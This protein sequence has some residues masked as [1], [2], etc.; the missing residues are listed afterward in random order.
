[1]KIINAMALNAEV[2]LIMFANSS[3]FNKYVVKLLKT[4]GEDDLDVMNARDLIEVYWRENINRAYQV[5]VHDVDTADVI[6]MLEALAEVN[7]DIEYEDLF[8]YYTRH[9]LGTGEWFD[10][11]Q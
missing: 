9:M 10:P 6:H 11:G 3:R 7:D 4:C 5:S 2:G 1:M 8:L